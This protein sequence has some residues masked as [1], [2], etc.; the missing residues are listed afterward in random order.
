MKDFKNI[1]IVGAGS[2]GIGIAQIAST[3]GCKVFLY[4]Q[5]VEIAQ[6]SLNKLK[7]ILERLIEKKRIN[8][9]KRD[10]ILS[11][12]K[13]VSSLNDLSVSNLIIEAIIE[14][15]NIKKD[16]FSKLETIVH[17]ECIIAS[18]TSSLS[19]TNLAS[20]LKNPSNF[21]GIHFFNPAP[22]MPL[23]E[24]IPALQ[25]N[26]NLLDSIRNLLLSWNKFP[27]IAKDT[28][29]FIVNRIARPFY[30]EALRI[31]DEQIADFATIDFAMK[32]VGGFK[33]GPFE[34]MDFIGND[35]NYAVTE[36]VFKSFYY[37][38]KYKPS[39]T[40]KQYANAGWLGRKTNKGYYDYNSSSKNVPSKDVTLLNLI[41]ER[42][43][44]ML[45]NDAVD[46]FYLGI[47]SKED[48]DLAIT[49]GVNYPKGLIA[50][51]EEKTF[52]WVE[53]KMDELY[54]NYKEDRY[55]CS[56]LVRKWGNLIK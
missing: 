34:L 30:S 37:D 39:L 40:Q 48:I 50:W 16:L 52:S 15:L 20:S 31:Y 9:N 25:T 56:P 24:I 17:K 41:F 47:A 4:D 42:I 44:V 22:L 43:L 32:E 18:N 11:N 26:I 14:N 55:R 7:K 36:S 5:N 10:E 21:I 38:P 2:M 53:K 46:A 1:G 54:E 51:G 33:M 28:P 12:I 27:V 45:I 23:V 19:I 13:I 29:G 3:S 8:S 35:V 6:S 49:K